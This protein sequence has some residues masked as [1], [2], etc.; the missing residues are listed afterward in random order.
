MSIVRPSYNRG[1]P[2]PLA[3]PIMVGLFTGAVFFFK[4]Q[5][6]DGGSLPFDGAFAQRA[7]FPLFLVLTGILTM[8]L[9]SATASARFKYKIPTPEFYPS[10][11]DLQLD[12]KNSDGFIKPGDVK[13]NHRQ[14]FLWVVRAHQNLLESLPV[15]LS[16]FAFIEL[17]SD[18]KAFGAVLYGIF[19]IGRYI[20][21]YMYSQLGPDRRAPGF[22]VGYLSLVVMHAVII[23]H[24][25]THWSA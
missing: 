1:A 16:L 15:A 10:L 20:N 8:V 24:V 14:K 19:L 18:F 6:Q 13:E 25:A 2:P 5:V 17:L 3:D 11:A 9:A 21:G 4:E 23:V 7:L 12:A 22:I